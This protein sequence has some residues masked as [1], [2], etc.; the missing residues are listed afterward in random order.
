M[1]KALAATQSDGKR[2]VVPGVID[3]PENWMAVAVATAERC[4]WES[5]NMASADKKLARREANSA[6]L[7]ERTEHQS[8]LGD[9]YIIIDHPIV[10]IATGLLNGPSL[11]D[12][13]K[14]KIPKWTFLPPPNVPETVQVM[15]DR[16]GNGRFEVVA[17][18]EFVVPDGGTDFPETFP[19][20]MLIE[21]DNL[22]QNSPC[23]VRFDHYPYNA[24]VPDESPITPLICDRLP[25]YDR[26]SPQALIFATTYLDDANLAPG[27]KLKAKIP[28]YADWQATDKIA[29]Y[30]VD[31]AH[32]PEE[33]T[34]LTPIFFDYVPAPGVTETEIE[35]DGDRVREFGDAEC[36]FIY[37]LIDQATNPSVLSLW[38]KISLTF[39]R[40][41]SNLQ[42]PE[43]PQADPGPLVVEHALS[44]VS[45][46]VPLYD[47]HKSYDFI[48]LKWGSTTLEDVSVGPNPPARI[49]IPVEP[50]LLMLREYGE[51][52]TG[53]KETNI[54]YQVVRKGR[55]FGPEDIDIHVNFEVP[56]PWIPWP[57]PDWPD[58]VHP[59]LT[60]GVVKNWDNS[61]TNQLTRADKDKQ[62]Y[63]TFTWYAEAVDGHVIDFFWNGTRVVEA[64][65]T[66]EASQHTP[67]DDETVE[68]PWTYIKD[69]GNGLTVPVH[70]Q[71]SVTDVENDLK[72]APT[73]V[74]V[75]AIAVELPAPSFPTIS[76][77][78]PG[79][80]V[81]D[82]DGALQVAI[83]DLSGVLKNGDQINFV[84]TPMRGEYLSDPEDPI[85]AAIF[86][87]D[88]VLGA[89]GTPLTGFI[90]RVAPYVDHILPLYDETAATDHR[91][92]AKIQYF[93]NDGSEILESTPH[94]TIT[95]FHMPSSP[96]EIPRP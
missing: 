46:W 81:L 64:Q 53:D 89:A 43:V 11:K 96:C 76:T 42:A 67:G 21:I 39:G 88:Y 36:V 41:P 79:C 33:P 84:F 47:N 3:L 45:V 32:I 40:L 54:S 72:S 91:G 93:H 23:R 13:L 61:R 14:V 1:L 57:A 82:D 17:E 26:D 4:Q 80:Q 34:G 30:L 92:R 74:N 51:N 35:I 66:F 2:Y 94:T 58:T 20:P 25:P 75:N 24:E 15:F 48:R 86:R 52:T 73:E 5:D 85:N 83:P 59:S 31:A 78:Y 56:I 10:D 38:Q 95:A 37:V 29:V 55:L 22:P 16:S 44:G 63:F 70:Y 8:R 62:A 60:V 68:I 6:Y 90:I 28:G 71:L 19:Y 27:S 65:I 69:G 9:A 49:E 87:R 50:K 18:H 7:R 12:G 77:D